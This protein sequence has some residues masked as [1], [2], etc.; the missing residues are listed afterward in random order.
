MYTP[1]SNL[2]EKEKESD[3]DMASKVLS[4]IEN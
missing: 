1:Y 3:R 4:V 2:T